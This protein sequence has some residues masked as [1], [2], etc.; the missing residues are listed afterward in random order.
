MRGTI[1]QTPKASIKEIK[2]FAVAAAAAAT[3]A[4]AAVAAA[5]AAGPQLCASYAGAYMPVFL[6]H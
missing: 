4:G 2:A 5:T 1:I 6:Q 3:A